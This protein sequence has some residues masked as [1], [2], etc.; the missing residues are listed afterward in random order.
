MA[1]VDSAEGHGRGLMREDCRPSLWS[2]SAEPQFYSRDV[3]LSGRCP[4][5]PAAVLT[6][7]TPYPSILGS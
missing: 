7:P 4:P 1:T 2:Y 6:K 5:P 3:C